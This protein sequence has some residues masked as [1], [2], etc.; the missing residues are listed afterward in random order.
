MDP[1]SVFIGVVLG[2]Y[3]CMFFMGPF[4][5]STLKYGVDEMVKQYNKWLDRIIDGR[6]DIETLKRNRNENRR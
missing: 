1:I 3:G 5:K 4:Y 2:F 6:V